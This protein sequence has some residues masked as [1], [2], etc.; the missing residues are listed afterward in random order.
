MTDVTHMTDMTD[1]YQTHMHITPS[2]FYTSDSYTHYRSCVM[3][4]IYGCLW[5]YKSFQ[6]YDNQVRDTLVLNIE[7]SCYN[8][9]V[10]DAT[11]KLIHIDWDNIKF[12]N[13][14]ARESN[15][16][17]SHLDDTTLDCYNIIQQIFNN[18]I[19]PINIAYM[20]S[21]ELM[22]EKTAEIEHII[23]IRNSQKIE[24]KT[25]TMYK[26][27]KC[28]HRESSIRETQIRSLDEGANI[29]ATCH[30]CTFSWI[31]A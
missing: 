20:H 29:L 11:K 16:V 4:R 21:K 17:L 2:I 5:G 22:P 7:L 1:T 13:I 6:A 23:Q 8:K 26:C 31:A 10:H 30:N 18:D 9:S 24:G 12:I 28:N 19:S 14:Y 25:S 3:K 27:P 15:R